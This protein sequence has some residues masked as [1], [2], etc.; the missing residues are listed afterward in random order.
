MLIYNILYLLTI[1]FCFL[2]TNVD[3]VRLNKKDI[4]VSNIAFCVLS[5]FI[6]MLGILRGEMLGTDMDTYR[7]NYW[8]MAKNGTIVDMMRVKDNWGYYIVNW[9]ICRLVPEF[10]MFKAILF[11]ITFG[12]IAF[13][14]RKH[15]NNI[16]ISILVFLSLDFLSFEFCILK[17]ALAV[18][19]YIWSYDFLLERKPI[20]FCGVV[21]LA[22][23]F[24]STALFMLVIYPF[25]T[26]KIK[27]V[28]NIRWIYLAG[29]IVMSLCTEMWCAFVYPHRDYSNALGDKSGIN[30]L[31]YYLCLFVVIYIFMKKV[32]VNKSIRQEYQCALLT[33]PFQIIAISINI[34]TRMLKYTTIYLF[35]L[36]PDIIMN[37]TNKKLKNIILFFL[38]CFLLILYVKDYNQRG[39]VPYTTWF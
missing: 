24:H 9:I 32:N 39:I 8:T 35:I 22:S 10:W 27:N 3:T 30:L 25:L 12:S 14:I 4:K 38:I 20:K 36:I 16:S 17:Q 26:Q 1:F 5:V 15:S 6:L 28:W 18:S 34:G 21:L 11:A 23:L 2:E 37:C 13:W 19:I 31:L 7:K 29:A 33:I